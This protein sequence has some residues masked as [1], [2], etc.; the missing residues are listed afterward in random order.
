M[1]IVYTGNGKGKTTAAIGVAAR[2]A[3]R[4]RKVLI[5]KFIKA[6]DSGEDL[7]DW[8]KLTPGRVKIEKH[9]LGFVGLPGDRFSRT[10]HAA[11]AEEGLRRVSAEK[12]N[13]DA[14]ILDEINVA[15]DLGLVA[16]ESTLELAKDLRR[17][18]KTVILTGRN[19]PLEFVEAADL[20]TEMREIKHPFSQGEPAEEGIDY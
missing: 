16:A 17:A 10:E 19:A 5:V 13:W 1:L 2:L 7:I 11:A 20:V 18:G 4:N 3:G 14:F 12:E 9:G 15:V 6:V 8:T